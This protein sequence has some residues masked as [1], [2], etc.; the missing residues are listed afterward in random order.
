[1]T[2]PQMPSMPARTVTGY[3][4]R[5]QTGAE[6]AYR[7]MH[8]RVPGAV[9][10]KLRAAG[11][12]SWSIWIDGGTLF[13]IIE[14]RASYAKTIAALDALGPVDPAWDEAVAQLID[15]SPDASA[16]LRRVWTLDIAGQR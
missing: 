8:A 9:A 16:K 15:P 14:T 2:R 10:E 6:E 5:V 3:R 11:V 12:L 4:T 1:M 7:A 13:H